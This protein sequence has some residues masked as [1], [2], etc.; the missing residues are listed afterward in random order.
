MIVGVIVLAIGWAAYGIYWY[1]AGLQEK[2]RPKIRSERYDKT[3]GE[4]KDYADKMS[5][6]KKPRYQKDNE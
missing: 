2:K 4:M 3:Q 1:I 6:Y 5:K